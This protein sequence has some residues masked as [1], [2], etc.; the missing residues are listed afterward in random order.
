MTRNDTPL[1]LFNWI[2]NDNNISTTQPMEQNEDD[3]LTYGYGFLLLIPVCLFLVITNLFLICIIIS[4]RKK[5][6][7]KRTHHIFYLI[8]FDLIVG[9]SLVLS[10]L[11]RLLGL[12][13]KKPY[14]F[15]AILSYIQVSPQAV[16]F[17]HI[18]AVCIHRFR[19]LRKIDPPN[20]IDKYRYGV[21]SFLIW[22]FVHLAC[23]PPYATAERRDDYISH[24]RIEFIFGQSNKFT[25]VYFL[26]LCFLPCVLANIIYAAVIVGMK[27]QLIA[28]RPIIH[29]VR[30]RNA[31]NKDTQSTADAAV[32]VGIHPPTSNNGKEVGQKPNKATRIIGYL[33]V[34]LN[35][36]YLSPVITFGMILG[37]YQNVPI[38]IQVLTYVNNVFSSFIYSF[39]ITPLRE[40]IKTTLK[41]IFPRFLPVIHPR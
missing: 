2:I 21:E 11:V 38:G 13:T 1:A 10:I 27:K 28:V 32:S 40:A 35:I 34:V 7:A 39:T 41:I 26:T 15:C 25:V 24:C 12:P 6:W 3:H 20:G 31:H 23:V 37:G 14:W 19:K 4:N 22:I 29:S 8:V 16:S 33:L 17:Y 30:F 9:F 5:A 18:L 36:S